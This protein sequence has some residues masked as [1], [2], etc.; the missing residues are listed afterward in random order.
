MCQHEILDYSFNTPAHIDVWRGAQL[1][2][3]LDKVI[4]NMFISLSFF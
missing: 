4:D 1:I 2:S 3:G